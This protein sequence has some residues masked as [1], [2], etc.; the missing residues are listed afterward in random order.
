MI[1][2][3][4]DQHF[5]HENI[6]R[7]TR[8]PYA[9]VEEMDEQLIANWNAVVRKTDTVYQLGDFTLGGLDYFSRYVE[10]LNGLIRI[11]PGS[12]DHYWLK[13]KRLNCYLEGLG[14]KVKVLAPVVTVHADGL[15]VVLCHYA[16]RVWDRS[17][18]GSLHLY[19]H[20]HGNLVGAEN[21]M[22][23]GVDA[24]SENGYRPISINEV[25]VALK[26]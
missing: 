13:E 23:V 19:G 10:R 15:I 6:I 3:T 18:Y 7:Y 14:G 26:Q 11:V 22:D 16:L 4:A 12:H 24:V 2:F 21:S 8:R 25:R 17:H 20:S 9:N 5:G 1:W